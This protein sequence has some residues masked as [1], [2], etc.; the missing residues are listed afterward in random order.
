LQDSLTILQGLVFKLRQGLD[1]LQFRLEILDGKTSTLL[2]ILSTF[3]GA[4]HFTPYATGVA[5]HTLASDSRKR[6]LPTG[7]GDSG[8]AMH[9][10]M[11]EEYTPIEEETPREYIVAGMGFHAPREVGGTW[12]DDRRERGDSDAET[13]DKMEWRGEVVEEEPWDQAIHATSPSGWPS[14]KPNV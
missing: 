3:Q 13:H 8:Q 12:L 9:V 11:D 14:Y 1:D 4:F 7:G 2:Q 10:A 5:E 6:G